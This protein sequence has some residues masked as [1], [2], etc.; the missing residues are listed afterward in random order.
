[1][2][3]PLD[4]MP[5]HLLCK[6]APRT[7]AYHRALWALLGWASPWPC[8]GLHWTVP[9]LGISI[10]YLPA[11]GLYNQ[12]GLILPHWWQATLEIFLTGTI[13]KVDYNYGYDLGYPQGDD[14]R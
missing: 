1:M 12:S 10:L 11:D 3:Y 4:R 7:W 5:P 14:H 8:H 2:I 9:M 13:L 6:L